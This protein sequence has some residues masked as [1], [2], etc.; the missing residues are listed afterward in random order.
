MDKT[1][2]EKKPIDVLLSEYQ[3]W[4][5]AVDIWKIFVANNNLE[6]LR[7]FLLASYPNGLSQADLNCILSF[8]IC[9]IRQNAK[10]R[11]EERAEE[12]YDYSLLFGEDDFDLFSD[13]DFDDSSESDKIISDSVEKHEEGVTEIKIPNGVQ[14]IGAHAFSLRYDIKSITIPDSVIRI[15]ESAFFGCCL[16]SM[17]IPK[18]VTNIGKFAF[19]YCEKLASIAIPESVTIIGH[20]AFGECSSLLEID[21]K[22]TKESWQ[23][24]RKGKYWRTN[25]G[26]RTIKCTDGIIKLRKS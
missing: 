15:E 5:C 23:A 8:K 3:P 4:D 18:N 17:I 16:E 6:E 24:I 14:R 13:D 22:G 21:Y 2:R 12:E 1:L 25:S 7:E 26:I 19:C 20:R 10:T 11:G 9:T